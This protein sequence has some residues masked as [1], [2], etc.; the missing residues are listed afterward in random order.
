MTMVTSNIKQTKTYQTFKETTKVENYVKYNLTTSERSLTAQLRF[1]ILPL[2]IETRHFR[3]IKLE[4]RLCIL[5]ELGEIEDEQHFL[6]N[7]LLYSQ[8]RQ[9]WINSILTVHENFNLLDNASKFKI[10]FG[11]FH[12]CT[13]KFI[14]QCFKIR[15]DNL[16]S[17]QG[18][19]YYNALL[20]YVMTVIYIVFVTCYA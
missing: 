16:L 13:A 6:F 1:G 3:N 18:S 11:K 19:S 7:C 17:S 14:S 8:L 12:R 15:K 9:T 5:C 10:I 4:E 20:K 2:T